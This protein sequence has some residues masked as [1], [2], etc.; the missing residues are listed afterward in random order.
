MFLSASRPLGYALIFVGMI[1]EGDIFLFTAGFLTRAGAF[2]LGDVLIF[3]FV[4]VI[5]GDLLWYTAGKKLVHRSAFISKWLEHLTGHFDN[6]LQE[7]TFHTIL[8]SKF[9]YGIHHPILA[10][11][12]H[13]KIPIKKFIE[14]DLASSILWLFVVGGLGYVSSLYFASIRHYLKFLEM[15]LLLAV[16]FFIIVTRII[17]WGLKKKL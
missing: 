7:H 17:S 14:D 13:L 16:L 11:A 1:L 6:H 9:I 2:D 15:A 10:R 12:G 8:I 3:A 4:G 5:V